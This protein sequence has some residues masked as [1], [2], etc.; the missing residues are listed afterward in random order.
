MK[1]DLTIYFLL[2]KFC[3]RVM[4]PVVTHDVLV[5][6]FAQGSIT[7]SAD[8]N[9]RR[10]RLFGGADSIQQ[11]PY[12]SSED[13]SLHPL[14]Q[15]VRLRLF[16]PQQQRAVLQSPL[17]AAADRSSELML[18][19][20]AAT[21]ATLPHHKLATL[22]AEA[23][24]PDSFPIDWLDLP[25]IAHSY[26]LDLHAVQ[27]SGNEKNV[28]ALA[29]FQEGSSL[30]IKMKEGVTNRPVHGES[31]CEYSAVS[32]SSRSLDAAARS[33]DGSGIAKLVHVAQQ[34]R[35]PQGAIGRCSSMREV[36]IHH[37]PRHSATTPITSSPRLPQCANSRASSFAASPRDSHERQM[38]GSSVSAIKDSFIRRYSKTEVSPNSPPAAADVH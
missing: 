26:K 18:R 17:S 2:T 25:A 6:G 19:F 33:T 34:P 36:G 15:Q 14:L 30:P 11:Q 32:A 8:D 4:R 38:R 7:D 16:A 35:A 24:S 27:P 23:A 10:A 28:S 12:D 21:S 29:G 1:F 22:R 5:R 31:T 3:F 13:F 37:K 20:C 9:G